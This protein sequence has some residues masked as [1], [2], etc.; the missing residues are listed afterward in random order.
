M[1]ADDAGI[2]V[3]ILTRDEEDRLPRTLAALR[4]R[5]AP[6]IVL[7]AESQDSTRAIAEHEGCEVH[8]RPWD[9][10]VAA[11]RHLIDLAHTE[12]ILM[13]DADEVVQPA[14]WDEVGA[15]DLDSVG[16]AGFAMRRRTVYLGRVLRRSWQP[17]WKTVLFRRD[18]ARVHD[19]GVHESIQL[20]GDTRRLHSEIH[21]HSYRSLADHQARIV[22]YAALG[23]RELARH[24]KTASWLDL[25]GRPAWAWFRQY[26]LMGG[27]V[28]GW[29]GHL[30]ARSTAWSVYLR[31]ALLAEMNRHERAE[32]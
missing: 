19:S 3:C 6:V 28:D 26:L 25:A 21:H 11:R 10:Y 18:R 4:D 1:A 32:R 13:I 31:Y 12:W 8:V 15:L 9:G 24:G 2:T 30:A 23:A 14:F 16:A 5:V 27:F 29:R 7:D 22:K 17:D 20:Y